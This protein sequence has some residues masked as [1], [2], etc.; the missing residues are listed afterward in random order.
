MQRALAR[1]PLKRFAHLRPR[2]LPAV[3]LVTSTLF[4]V[5][6]MGLAV[7]AQAQE[8]PTQ[9]TTI[10]PAPSPEQASQAAD[11]A[12]DD[13]ETGGDLLHVLDQFVAG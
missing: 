13:A 6:A 8:Q 11:A 12:D 4:V 5:K 10:T 9:T 1:L 2:L 3:M 7:E